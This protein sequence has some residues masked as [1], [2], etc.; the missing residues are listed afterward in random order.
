MIWLLVL[1]KHS[2]VLRRLQGPRAKAGRIILI[3]LQMKKI[4]KKLSRLGPGWCGWRWR[5]LLDS[6]YMLEA[7]Q[8]YGNVNTNARKAQFIK[9]RNW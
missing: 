3:R 4:P 2:A 1:K 6:R 5:E 9:E 7:Q 8:D